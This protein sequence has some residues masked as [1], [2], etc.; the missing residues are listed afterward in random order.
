[1][2]RQCVE[3]LCE[4]LP[5]LRDVNVVY[6]Y[7]MPGYSKLTDTI[8][9]NHDFCRRILGDITY[10]EEV[11]KKLV[12]EYNDFILMCFIILHEYRHKVQ[13]DKKLFDFYTC[14]E[15]YRLTTKNTTEENKAKLY[16]EIPYERDADLFAC[17]FIK[18][19]L[20][21]LY[22]AGVKV[23]KLRKYILGENA[24]QDRTSWWKNGLFSVFSWKKIPE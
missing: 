12:G 3:I 2:Y 20:D 6:N 7:Q 13:E 8:I 1:M 18:E 5:Q 22:S 24:R 15:S 21:Y 4:I 9:L 19:H 17:E 23:P 14:Y 11:V 10:L 16:R